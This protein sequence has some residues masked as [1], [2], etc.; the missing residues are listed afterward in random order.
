MGWRCWR[1]ASVRGSSWHGNLS[2]V[3]EAV[4]LCAP[5]AGERGWESAVA[6]CPAL[7]VPGQQLVGH[8]VKRVLE[9]MDPWSDPA[10]HF[11]CSYELVVDLWGWFAVDWQ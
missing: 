5:V 10:R 2:P 6:P 9:Q 8:Y 7:L 3:S 11:L 1:P 4:S